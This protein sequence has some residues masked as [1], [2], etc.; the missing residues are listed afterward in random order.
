MNSRFLF[1]AFCFL[2][3]SG[4]FYSSSAEA[5]AFSRLCVRDGKA[6]SKVRIA[7][8]PRKG[9]LCRRN[10]HTVLRF[11]PSKGSNFDIDQFFN[12]IGNLQG[13][14]GDKGDRGA[15]GA[16]GPAGATGAQGQKGD[17]GD[18]GETGAA[19]PAGAQGPAG[20]QGPAGA[21]GPQGPA[22]PTGPQ[23]STGPQGP[24]GPTGPTGPQGPAGS[25][26]N[27]ASCRREL[28]RG[29]YGPA[30]VGM[31]GQNSTF[32]SCRSGEYMVAH[33]YS[34]TSVNGSVLPVVTDVVIHA[35][36]QG[37]SNAYPTGVTINGEPIQVTPSFPGAQVTWRFEVNA[38]CCLRN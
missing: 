19:G 11:I 29:T 7:Y 32:V 13:T 25:G 36:S 2:V 12:N 23:G 6:E 10:E 38:Y 28:N 21:T 31:E 24:A 33:S 5:Q 37:T 27:F 14:K 9:K 35:P 4:T 3:L 26:T 20:P 34:R 30:V 18:R 15:T 8:A 16:Q 17:K 1:K 22:G